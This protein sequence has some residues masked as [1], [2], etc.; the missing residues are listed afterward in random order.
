MARIYTPDG[1]AILGY[2][3]LRSEA[4]TALINAAGKAPP[5]QQSPTAT[6]DDVYKQWSVKKYQDITKVS[7]QAYKRAWRHLTALHNRPIRY[8][9]VTDIETTVIKEDPAVNTRITIKILLNQ[10]YQYAVAHDLADRNLSEFIDISK[11]PNPA[12]K[13]VRKP[14][15]FGEVTD[16][17]A[18]SDSTAQLVLIGIY[19]GMRPSELLH[20]SHDEIDLNT[21]M[22]R[23]RGSKTQSGYNRVIPI[24]PAILQIL[25]RAKSSRYITT[26]RLGRP[27]NYD[28]YRLWLAKH[29]HTPHDTRHTF[30]TY[31]LKSNMHPLAVKRI[32]GHTVKD[33]TESVY[34][35][36]DE[37]FLIREMQKYAIL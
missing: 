19:T 4:M 33:I 26:N 7:I 27:I 36:L 23:I 13:L 12:D 1:Y 16:L 6:L 29:G 37:P 2:F 30:A 15:T 9:T 5:C 10:L 3:R 24:H 35:H 21:G 28:Y 20:L 25:T 31:A 11:R 18:S 22:L 32:M 14:F 34:T 17:F 8:I